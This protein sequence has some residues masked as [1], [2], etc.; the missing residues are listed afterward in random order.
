M[1]IGTAN[2][3][4]QALFQMLGFAEASRS[5]VFDE[6]T[7]VCQGPHLVHLAEL[8]LTVQDYVTRGT[9]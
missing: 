6:V 7:M 1:K 8:K 3:G 9:Q 5:A 2:I 4:S